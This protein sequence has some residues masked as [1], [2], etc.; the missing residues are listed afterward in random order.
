MHAMLHP[1]NLLFPFIVKYNIGKVNRT[2][3]K[4]SDEFVKVVKT[5]VENSSDDQSIYNRIIKE[6]P[7]IPKNIVLVDII[8]LM[9]G[10]DGTS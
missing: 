2:N 8:N 1:I 10:G 9:K 7:T 4:N 3:T 5:F 6:E